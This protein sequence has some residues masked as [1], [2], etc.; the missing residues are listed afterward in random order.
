MPMFGTSTC[1]EVT[2][3]LASSAAARGPEHRRPHPTGGTRYSRNTLLS[4]TAI[5]GANPLR[6]RSSGIWPITRLQERRRVRLPHHPAADPDLALGHPADP[7]Q[8]LG[9]LALPVARHP[10]HADDLAGMDRQVDIR[11]RLQPPLVQR[12]GACA[13]CSTM[14]PISRG[15]VDRRLA[16]ILDATSRPTINV[17]SLRLVAFGGRQRRHLLARPAAR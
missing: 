10:G 1:A 13:N 17:A 9:Q 4:A 12:A 7:G 5:A 16:R 6:S 3:C 11:Q 14:L 8:H 2:I 15:P